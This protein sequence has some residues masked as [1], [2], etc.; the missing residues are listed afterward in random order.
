M[1]HFFHSS[2]FLF[3]LFVFAFYLTHV[4]R[5]YCKFIRY[6]FFD[7]SILLSRLILQYPYTPYP[8]LSSSS[9]FFIWLFVLRDEGDV[10][11]PIHYILA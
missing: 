11:P 3:L 8:S 5:I 7:L 6:F 10:K 9:I 4:A 1:S 2:F